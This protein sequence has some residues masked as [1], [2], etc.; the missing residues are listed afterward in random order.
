[1]TKIWLIGGAAFLT[2]LVVA[3]IVVALTQT[4]KPLTEGSPEAAVQGFLRA[5][6]AKETQIAYDFFSNDLKSEC[7]LED[8]GG[9]NFG[10]G[11]IDDSRIV[12]DKTDV[13]DG[14]A[15]VTLQV[16]QFYGNGLFGSS[17][18]THSE[19]FTLSKESGQWKLV[20]NPWPYY[21]CG[22]SSPGRETIKVAPAE[23]VDSEPT[24]T[25][26]PAAP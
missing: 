21:N 18:S 22:P 16:T 26:T 20:R 17:E 15:F 12:F 13:V 23:K 6:E 5:T 11:Q 7:P 19:Q 1:M 10:R 24:A 3:A 8:F 14:T 2:I 25:A 9:R 4:E